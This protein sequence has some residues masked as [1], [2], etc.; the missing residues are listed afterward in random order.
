[1][2]A[3]GFEVKLSARVCVRAPAEVL[4][5]TFSAAAMLSAPS[6]SHESAEFLSR[7]L[8]QNLNLSGTAP[9]YG[10]E[11]LTRPTGL[12]QPNT[13]S[14][15]D[16]DRVFG[17]YGALAFAGLGQP[18]IGV[19]VVCRSGV[20][21]QIKLERNMFRLKVRVAPLDHRNKN[22]SDPLCAVLECGGGPLGIRCC[23]RALASPLA[24]IRKGI[25]QRW[26][27]QLLAVNSCETAASDES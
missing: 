22:P 13:L 8:E 19:R 1:M 23:F 17:T 25:T 18:E 11:L 27:V 15:E 9:I 14:A 3:Y 26:H 4:H 24:S 7:V 5:C 21:I 2:S 20:Q 12:V 16:V 10:A 6:P